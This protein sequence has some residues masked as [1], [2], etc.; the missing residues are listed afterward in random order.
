MMVWDCEN[1][2]FIKKWREKMAVLS[3]M[4]HVEYL[5]LVTAF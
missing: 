1:L 5:D 4:Y 2:E 3:S